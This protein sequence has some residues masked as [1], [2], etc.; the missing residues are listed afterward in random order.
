MTQLLISVRSLDEFKT[1]IDA[2]VEVIDV[3]EPSR[4]SLGRADLS[5]IRQIANAAPNTI[6]LSVALGELANASEAICA[7][8][9]DR[10]DYVKFGLA[11][12]F[13]IARWRELWQTQ[14]AHLHEKTRAVAVAYADAWQAGAPPIEDVIQTGLE[15]GCNAIL[16]DTF[17]KDTGNLLHHMTV[18]EITNC[19]SRAR[20]DGLF[21]AL[22]GSLGP[23][24]IDILFDL[25]PDLL[26]FR[27]AACRGQRASTISS[28]AIGT[29]LR[30]L[31]VRKK[32][33]VANRF[34]QPSENRLR[35][36]QND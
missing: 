20:S 12:C 24:A 29:L 21:V 6:T 28:A 9:P 2:G 32:Q 23:E 34:S 27:S 19:I 25:E 13:R 4:G 18:S 33:G 16:I 35:T 22:A 15:V 36:R 3:K 17:R 14:M 7:S 30:A 11:G 31:T 5:T 26:A 8:L 10:V 1:A